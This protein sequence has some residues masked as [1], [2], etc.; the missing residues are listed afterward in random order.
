MIKIYPHDV[1]STDEMDLSAS[2]W[3]EISRDYQGYEL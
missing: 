2:V 1:D 3:W